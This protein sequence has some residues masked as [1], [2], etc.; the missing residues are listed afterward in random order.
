M[1]RPMTIAPHLSLAE[2]T[3]TLHTADRERRRGTWLVM[4]NALVDPRPAATI[5][6]HPAPSRW[7]VH[8][9][10]ADDHRL[11]PAGIAADRRGGRQH[12]Y[13]PEEEECT[14]LE[15]VIACFRAGDLI[16]TRVIPQAFAERVGQSV[17]AGTS[18]GLLHRHDWHTM[19]PRPQ[20]PNADPASQAQ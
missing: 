1:A 9:P 15:P 10:V 12:A 8:H 19:T 11:G 20:H 2:V 4:D 5:A 17:H 3:A 18:S 14:V 16:T 13:L 7:V 6:V